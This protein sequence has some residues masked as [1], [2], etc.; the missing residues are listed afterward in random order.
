MTYEEKYIAEQKNC[1]LEW[2][3]EVYNYHMLYK[4][5]K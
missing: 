4:N 5:N 3:G 1:M 2:E